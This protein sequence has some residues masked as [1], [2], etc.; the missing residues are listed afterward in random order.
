MNDDWKLFYIVYVNEIGSRRLIGPYA[1]RG[2]VDDWLEF[3]TW[4]YKPLY[5]LKVKLRVGQITS[6]ILK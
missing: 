2:M 1:Y 4:R 6:G 5:I 3:E